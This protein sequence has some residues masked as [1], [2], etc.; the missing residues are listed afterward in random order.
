MAYFLIPLIDTI[1]NFQRVQI[2]HAHYIWAQ[3]YIITI[4]LVKFVQCHLRMAICDV[5]E[6]P[7][8]GQFCEK[9]T[10][11]SADS[12]LEVIGSQIECSKK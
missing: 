7:Q 8:I 11:D 6:P 2:S 12:R 1:D 5:D 9:W 4:L 3:S 10:W